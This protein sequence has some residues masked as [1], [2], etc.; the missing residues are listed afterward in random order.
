MVQK[1]LAPK[2]DGL[3]PDYELGFFERCLGEAFEIERSERLESGTRVLYHARPK[4]LMA[5]EGAA[6]RR[7]QT[8]IARE[9]LWHLANLAVLWTFAVAQPLFDLLG[10]NP[11]FFAAAA[12]RGSTSSPSRSCWW[13]CRRLVLLAIELLLRLLGR[14]FFKGA[15]MVFIAALVAL[16][17]AQALKKS[18]DASDGVLIGL[19][20]RS[21]SAVA[22][23]CARA[24]PVRS[25]LNVLTP[26]PLVFLAAVPARPPC[27]KLAFPEE[28]GRAPRWRDAGAGRGGAARRAPVEH[29]GRRARP[30]RHQALPGLRRARRATPPGSRTRT[31][32]YDSTSAPSR[33]SWT[34]TSRQEDRSDLGDHPNSIFSL[35]AQDPPAERVGGGHVGLL[36]RPLQ[37]RA[38]DEPYGD[39]L[40]SM[41][42]DLGLVWLHVV[43]PP[44]NRGRPQLGVRELGRLRRRR[45]R[46]CRGRRAGSARAEHPGQ[47]G[48][49]AAA[50]F[51][52]WIAKIRNGR[53]PAL[54]FKHTLHAARALA[55]PARRAPLPAP[56]NDAIPGMSNQSLQRPGPAGRAAPAPLPPDRLRRPRAQELWRHLKREGMWDNSLIVVAADHGV[57]FLKGRRD[58][59]TARRENYGEIAPIP[60]LHQGA[61]PEEG[62]GQRRLRRR[63]STS[64]PRSSTS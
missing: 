23:L 43:S 36:A 62:Q 19:S 17:A 18:I 12:R 60:L 21:A 14:P 27:P 40:S 10:D 31:P 49:A 16:I 61:G 44:G 64:C 28:A 58:R 47:P 54:N 7:P 46:R 26:A 1:L 4:R 11:E 25:F 38:A 51:E 63:R 8:T 32:I 20:W 9:A 2:R 42:E 57:A 15:H 55:V 52:D 6:G 22:A 33:R 29:A 41:S 53:R 35:F 13:C 24:E 56:P 34:A 48:R 50:R 30:A 59:R 45:R 39:R 5:T 37:G 3:H